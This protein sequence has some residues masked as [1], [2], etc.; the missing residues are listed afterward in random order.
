MIPAQSVDS[1]R[2]DPYSSIV[3][4]AYDRVGPAV[5]S[6]TARTANGRPLGSG[7]GVLYTPD[8]YLLTN[9]HVVSAAAELT[10][11]LTDGRELPATLVGNDPETDLAVLRLARLRVRG[12]RRV[13]DFASR[14]AGDRDRQ[15]L[16]LSSDGDG[17]LT[18]PAVTVA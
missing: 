13:L 14:P 12:I 9:S 2:L 11:A 8:G 4:D 10:A 16:R 5:A 3:A 18:I 15:S 7:S 6:I 1:A 17:A